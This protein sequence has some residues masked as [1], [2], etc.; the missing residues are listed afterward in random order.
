MTWIGVVGGIPILS[1]SATWASRSVASTSSRSKAA[2][3]SCCRA[4]ETCGIVASPFRNCASAD[5]RTARAESTALCATAIFP[6]RLVR[7]RKARWTLK[8][9]CWCLRLKPRLAAKRRSFAASQAFPRR[10]KSRSN[11]RRLRVGRT[12]FRI[13]ERNRWARHH[14]AREK[15]HSGNLQAPTASAPGSIRSRLIQLQSRPGV[16]IPTRHAS[17]G[18]ARWAMS[19]SSTSS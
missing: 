4:R 10:P 18:S 3:A 2:W 15:P 16:Q 6:R 5:S 13:R 9:I 7:P 8:M 17:P 1:A 11:H 12:W 19:I 14:G